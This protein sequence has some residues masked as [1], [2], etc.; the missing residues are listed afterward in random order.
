MNENI[1]GIKELLSPHIQD[2]KGWIGS[3]DFRAWDEERQEKA[4]TYENLLSKE[5][6]STMTEVEVH[7]L[8]STLWAFG[9]WGN[10]D[11]LVSRLLKAV[12]LNK[13]KK[14]L[15]EL[16]WG[17]NPLRKRYDDFN[18][19]VKYLGSAAITEILAFVH[20]D[21]CAI[22]NERARTGLKR[23]GLLKDLVDQ[24]WI[25][26]RDYEKICSEYKGIL[27]ALSD[28][29]I[30]VRALLDVDLFVFKVSITEE[31][32]KERERPEDY[33]FNHTEVKDKILEVGQYLGF[34]A[35]KE[36]LIAPGAQVDAIWTIS[37][38]NL[39]VVKYVFEVQRRG[40]VDSLLIKLHA[41]RKNPA[42]QKAII[43]SNTEG[44][45]KVKDKAE[46]LGGEF[47]KS[48][49]YLE[50]ADI[51]K[52]SESL[53]EAWDIISSLELIKST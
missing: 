15:M 16:L 53:K 34:A 43:V 7:E 9:A 25:S 47:A 8:I 11:Y 28:S 52:V 4:S 40:S 23:I 44:I 37:L 10:K 5:G 51:L 36:V 26:G 32:E 21:D 17:S 20:P 46:L 19:N 42:V 13:F 38:G 2:Y 45:R 14:L 49:A 50:V 6:I 31:I 24:Y 12:E 29:D 22:W 3:E 27:A 18:Q 48:L 1:S 30:A 33:D 35:E 39:G 41:A